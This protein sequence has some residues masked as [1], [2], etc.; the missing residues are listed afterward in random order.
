MFYDLAMDLGMTEMADF[1]RKF[2]LGQ[3]TRI[4][5]PGERGGLIPDPEWKRRNRGEPWYSGETVIH[6][7]GQ[8]YMQVT[9]LQLATAAA[10]VANH[11]RPVRPYLLAETGAVD[12]RTDAGA[13]GE[14]DGDAVVARAREPAVEPI[15]LTVETDWDF[16]ID[17]MVGVTEGERGTARAIGW[18]SPHTIAGKTGTAQV[19]SIAQGE[20]YDSEAIAKELRD[21]ALFIAFAPAKAPRIA[22]A[23]VVENG[24][25]GS[26]TAAPIAQKLIDRWLDEHPPPGGE[27]DNGG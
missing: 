11:G 17:A 7:I 6:G 2:G 12:V 23:V 5:L 20:E 25:S 19:F 8:G 26:G 14:P 21:H 1:L 24:G 27:D 22:V 13:D 15:D 9:P 18:K 10:Q 16:V 4:D 3:P